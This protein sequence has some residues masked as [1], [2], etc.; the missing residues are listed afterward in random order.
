MSPSS[1]VFLWSG[2]AYACQIA[3]LDALSK[4]VLSYTDLHAGSWPNWSL[5]VPRGSQRRPHSMISTGCETVSDFGILFP[6]IPSRNGIGQ[7]SSSLLPNHQLCK[8]GY[9]TR[10]FDQSRPLKPANQRNIS[11]APPQF[12][13]LNF[14]K[15]P[16]LICR[17]QRRSHESRATLQ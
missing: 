15:Q 10:S 5:G 9:F 2:I 3:R 6:S 16:H 8:S 14:P 17:Q 4:L 1:P 7:P 13:F 11:S 12:L